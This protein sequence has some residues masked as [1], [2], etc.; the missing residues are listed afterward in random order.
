MV[1]V[2]DR[3][4]EFK[5]PVVKS[6]C[7]PIWRGFEEVWRWVPYNIGIMDNPDRRLDILRGVVKENVD[8]QIKTE[9]FLLS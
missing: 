5:S 4:R 3:T 2:W 6:D 9:D 1:C 8:D 7:N